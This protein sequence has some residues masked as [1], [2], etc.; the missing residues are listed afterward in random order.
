MTVCRGEMSPEE[1]GRVAA[2]VVETAKA[3]QASNSHLGR[4]TLG[5]EADGGY[6]RPIC[7][8]IGGYSV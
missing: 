4:R 6:M 1:E 2:K 3:I 8:D 7:S 5:L